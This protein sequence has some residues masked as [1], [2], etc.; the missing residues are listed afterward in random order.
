MIEGY[1]F[2]FASA[3]NG[4]F[5][6]KVTELSANTSNRSAITDLMIKVGRIQLFVI[7]I[8]FIG[9]ITLGEEFILHSRFSNI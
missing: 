3:L 6:P 2:T 1:V 9:I 7:G 8:L 5:L 4:L